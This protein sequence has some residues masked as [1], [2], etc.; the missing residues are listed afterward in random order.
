MNLKFNF[1]PRPARWPSSPELEKAAFNGASVG[2]GHLAEAQAAVQREMSGARSVY[3]RNGDHDHAP[4]SAPS[5]REE[6]LSK[7]RSAEVPASERP[8]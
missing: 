2:R 4:N 5:Q 3:Q 1:G 6:L 7:I 8:E